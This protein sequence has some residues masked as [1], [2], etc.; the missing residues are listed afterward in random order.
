MKTKEVFF[1]VEKIYDDLYDEY[2]KIKNI[3]NKYTDITNMCSHE[4]A[5]KIV[6]NHPRKMMIDGT[7]YCPACGKSITCDYK[8]GFLLSSFK[9]SRI[10]PLINLSLN[11]E[12]EVFTTIRN[13][14][15]NNMA[16]YYNKNINTSILSNKMEEKLKD[17]QCDYMQSVLRKTKK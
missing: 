2:E 17:K 12:E 6:D 14:V 1:E 8:E 16:M 3:R 7:Y 11:A 13:E 9:N 15:F 5:F 4:I 10:I